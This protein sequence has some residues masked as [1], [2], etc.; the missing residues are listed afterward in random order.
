MRYCAGTLPGMVGAEVCESTALG[1]PAASSAPNRKVQGLQSHIH[2]AL[3]PLLLF[4]TIKTDFLLSP[5]VSSGKLKKQ[6]T[7]LVLCIN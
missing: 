6:N 7:F 4:I 5:V 1:L 2:H 3:S